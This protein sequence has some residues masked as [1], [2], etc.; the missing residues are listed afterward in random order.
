[1][2][3]FLELLRKGNATVGVWPETLTEMVHA[4]YEA[5]HAIAA[6]SMLYEN[7]GH[8]SSLQ[9]MQSE[10]RVQFLKALSVSTFQV[11]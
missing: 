1:M 9:P 5:F 7:E 11:L 10:K 8:L 3:L 6:T 2:A 4:W